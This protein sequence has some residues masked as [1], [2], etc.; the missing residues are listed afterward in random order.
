MGS[1][2]IKRLKKIEAAAL[3]KQPAVVKQEIKAEEV[4]TPVETKPKPKK[5]LKIF[6]DESDE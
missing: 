5:K 4:V 6:E 3:K 1:L 2:R